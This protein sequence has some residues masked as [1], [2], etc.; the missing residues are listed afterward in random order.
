MRGTIVEVAPRSGGVQYRL[1]L[2]VEL[3]GVEKPAMVG[4]FIVLAFP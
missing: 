1:A 3:E 2:A 4:E